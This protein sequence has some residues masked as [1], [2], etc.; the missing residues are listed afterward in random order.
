MYAV[1]A[2]HLGR[3]EYRVTVEANNK[4]VKNQFIMPMFNFSKAAR[5]IAEI[6]ETLN[7]EHDID[8]EDISICT[9]LEE[10]AERAGQKIYAIACC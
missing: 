8:V 3:R 5:R 6:V 10:A 1:S 4:T 7:V 9:A 2:E